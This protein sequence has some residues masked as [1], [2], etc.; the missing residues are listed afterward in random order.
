MKPKPKSNQIKSNQNTVNITTNWCP[1]RDI[2]SRNSSS[3]PEVLKRHVHSRATTI[4]DILHHRYVHHVERIASH[5]CHQK[6][7]ERHGYDHWKDK[8]YV[9]PWTPL[10]N[11]A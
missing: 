2:M 1:L 6:R 8:T 9:T 5:G 10:T 3:L 4:M 7:E 11:M